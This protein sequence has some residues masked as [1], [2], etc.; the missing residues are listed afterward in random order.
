ML[1]I[2]F[3]YLIFRDVKIGDYYNLKLIGEKNEAKQLAD[4]KQQFLANM[5]HEIR[6]PLNA[7]IGFTEQLFDTT[8]KPNQQQYLEAV[9]SSSQHLLQNGT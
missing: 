1:G 4:S 8:L 6:T 2:I 5:S 3:T 7:I 9:H